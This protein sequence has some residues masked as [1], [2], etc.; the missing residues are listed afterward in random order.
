MLV[1]LRSMG[2]VGVSENVVSKP[3]RVSQSRLQLKVSGIVLTRVTFFYVLG[4]SL[5]PVSFPSSRSV[6]HRISTVRKM[7]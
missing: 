3:V 2:N 1:Y 7:S 6:S 5:N 4:Q